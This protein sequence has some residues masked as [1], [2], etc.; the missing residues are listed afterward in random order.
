MGLLTTFIII[1]LILFFVTIL[2]NTR[3]GFCPT[4][5]LQA[6]RGPNWHAHINE[7]GKAIWVDTKRPDQRGDYSCKKMDKCPPGLGPNICCWRCYSVEFQPQ[8]KSEW[9]P[10]AQYLL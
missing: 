5:P 10:G 7:Y 3:E 9:H 8:Y 1:T 2:L 4:S 6:V